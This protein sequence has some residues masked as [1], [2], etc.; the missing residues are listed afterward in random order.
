MVLIFFLLAL[1]S[2]VQP[3]ILT[4]FDS[5]YFKVPRKILAQFDGRIENY[6]QQRKTGE[7]MIFRQ[8]SKFLQK[9]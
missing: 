3:K 8:I 4:R 7:I 5:I 1:L 6:A 9:L 2:S